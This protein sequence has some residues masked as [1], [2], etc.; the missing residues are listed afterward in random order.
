MRVTTVNKRRKISKK[1]ILTDSGLDKIAIKSEL[2]ELFEST[3][4]QWGPENFKKILDSFLTKENEGM[5]AR[6]KEF[7]HQQ[8]LGK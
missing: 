4:T 8:S 2:T 1:N 5:V 7:L 6:L 3:A